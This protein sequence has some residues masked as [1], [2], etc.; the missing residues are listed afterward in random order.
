MKDPTEPIRRKAS[1]YPNVGEGTPCTQSSFKT[2]GKAFLFVGVQVGL[3]K[4][5]FKLK[6]SKAEAASLAEERPRD[7]QVGS[8]I[9]V[10]KGT[11]RCRRMWNTRSGASITPAYSDYRSSLE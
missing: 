6:K 10:T 3:Y 4:A 8:A 7:F 11:E 2:G 1:K 9:Q 5:M